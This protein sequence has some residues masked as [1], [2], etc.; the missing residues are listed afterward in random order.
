MKQKIKS[1][2]LPAGVNQEFVDGLQAM[3]T[4]Q[5]KAAI[6]RLQVQNQ[7][8]EAFKESDEFIAAQV[9]FD[10][11]KDNYLLVAGPVKEVT[12]SVRNRTK[13]VVARL[14]EKGGC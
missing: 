5:L 10:M 7:E 4:D 8:N 12:V 2:K 14:K 13:I 11:A 3:T 1:P 6:V 9:E